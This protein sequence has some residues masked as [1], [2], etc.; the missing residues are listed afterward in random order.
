MRWRALQEESIFVRQNLN[1]S[2]LEVNDIQ[3]MINNGDKHLADRIMKYGEGLRRSRQ[4][5]MARRYELTDMIKQIG[6]QGLIFFTFSAADF[7]WPELHKL[8]NDE[9]DFDGE[10]SAKKRQ[11]NIMKNPHIAT[12][13][14]NKRFDK[15]FNDVLKPCWDLEDW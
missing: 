8:M 4:F 2:Q 10:I 9:G 3:E 7:H 13:F 15:F 12:W 6:H 14:F 11:E 5:W 1:E